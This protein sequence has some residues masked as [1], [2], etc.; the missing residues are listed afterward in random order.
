MKLTTTTAT[1]TSLN[2]RTLTPKDVAKLQELLSNT[3]L[4]WQDD[5]CIPANRIRRNGRGVEVARVD[6][7]C[8]GYQDAHKP[9]M[10]GWKVSRLNKF[11]A[12]SLTRDYPLSPETIPQ[13]M[14]VA[15]KLADAALR[16]LYPDATFLEAAP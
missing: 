13:I 3:I 7:H 15:E 6:R 5:G 8:G 2:L 14:Q 1:T 10:I 12:D 4:P 16:C 9:A 11:I